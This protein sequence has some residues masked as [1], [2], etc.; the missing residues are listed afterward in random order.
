[1]KYTKRY[2]W[3]WIDRPKG[4]DGMLSRPGAS[5]VWKTTAAGKAALGGA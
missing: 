2:H 5:T 3:Q 1:M 4:E